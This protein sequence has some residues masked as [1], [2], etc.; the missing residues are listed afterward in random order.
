MT[1]SNVFTAQREQQEAEL[2]KFLALSLLGSTV[3]HGVVL[4]LSLNLVKPNEFAEEPIEF[5]LVEEPEVVQEKV[6]QTA[7]P[8]P[9]EPQIEPEPPQVPEPEIK[10]EP[11]EVPAPEIKPEPP[12]VPAPEPEI[13]PAPPSIPAP[14]PEISPA[15]PSIPAPEPEINPAPLQAQAPEPEINQAAQKA[16]PLEP[17]NSSPPPIEQPAPSQPVSSTRPGGSNNR[18]DFLPDV[19]TSDTS[20]NSSS[21][22]GEFEQ[23]SSEPFNNA[24][25]PLPKPSSNSPAI[26]NRPG[27]SN[28]TGDFLPDVGNPNPSSS[29]SSG[30]GDFDAP[31]SEP[32]NN[33]GGQLGSPASNSPVTTTRPGAS[34]NS[35]NSLD[36]LG[37]PGGSGIPGGSNILTSE[38]GNGDGEIGSSEPFGSGSGVMGRSPSSNS[39][40]I[41]TRPGR[42][43]NTGDFL[44]GAGNS[45]DSGIPGGGGQGSNNSG[46][47]G[48][49]TDS[50]SPFGNGSGAIARGGKPG[51]SGGSSRRSGPPPGTCIR[52]GKPGYPSQAR[53][54]G[55]EGQV[56]VK[57]D[58]DPEGNSFN[59]EI[60]RSSGHDDFDRAAIETVKNWK[61]SASDSGLRGKTASILFRLN[62]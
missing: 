6:V 54:E 46:L 12:K 1:F 56:Q 11:P 40:A 33:G 24:G 3:L 32:L 23:P 17:E 20:K 21:K 29:S 34:S 22:S 8:A 59:I 42:G 9:P 52:C 14:E 30:S 27:G 31:A 15:P 47:G 13:Q 4:P 44:P 53:K 36:D 43:N 61:F 62:D 26:A 45:T 2:K 60:L 49:G 48:D 5:V 57:F 10:P 16:P 41:A 28:N 18:D 50:S 39:Q 38:G 35:G 19:E 58:L 51:S 37:N 55:R 25:E 7:T